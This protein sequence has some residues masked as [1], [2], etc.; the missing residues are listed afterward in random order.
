MAM[1]QFDSMLLEN[2]FCSM[3]VIDSVRLFTNT[4]IDIKIHK[5]QYK[6]DLFWN[7]IIEGSYL[8]Y[9]LFAL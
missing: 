7:E 9:I 2:I 5:K 8:F 3:H 1:S 4:N 6:G